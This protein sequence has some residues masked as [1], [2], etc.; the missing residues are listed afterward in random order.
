MIKLYYDYIYPDTE[1]LLLQIKS[2]LF[3]LEEF[4]DVIT[5][6]TEQ[7]NL[8]YFIFKDV[9]FQIEIFDLDEE[10]VVELLVI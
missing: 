3:L 10:I 4:D 2:D 8:F 1:H 9:K 5:E 6:T 7:D